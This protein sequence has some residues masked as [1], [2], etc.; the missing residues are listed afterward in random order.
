MLSCAGID[1]KRAVHG[2]DCA[3]RIRHRD[4]TTGRTYD[5]LP[6][7]NELERD[8]L[9][10]FIDVLGGSAIT[11]IEVATHGFSFDDL[12]PEMWG[13]EKPDK[14]F[15]KDKR[16]RPPDLNPMTR[17]FVVSSAIKQTLW[18]LENA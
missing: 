10:F 7:V 9:V 11:R 8:V 12:I 15:E 13:W 6:V 17:F 14:R 3:Y 16:F 2:A 1:Q 4:T 5:L 18:R